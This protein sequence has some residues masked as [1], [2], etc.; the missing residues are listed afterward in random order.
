MPSNTVS[1][2]LRLVSGN[3]WLAW[4]NLKWYDVLAIVH[5]VWISD[6]N[7][8][9]VWCLEIYSEN[10]G[11][12]TECVCILFWLTGGWLAGISSGVCAHAS[13]RSSSSA[14][15]VY[16]SAMFLEARWLLHSLSVRTQCHNNHFSNNP[17][18]W[19]QERRHTHILT[20]GLIL[21]TVYK[22]F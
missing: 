10:K 5:N 7:Q 20:E 22:S 13:G 19:S 17:R 12:W 9:Q 15:C 6:L 11:G 16:R 14:W 1:Y 18:F 8:N 4:P 3:I 2:R 21:E